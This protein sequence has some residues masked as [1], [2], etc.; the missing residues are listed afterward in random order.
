MSPVNHTAIYRV[1]SGLLIRRDQEQGGGAG[2]SREPRRGQDQG[3]GAGLRKLDNPLLQLFLNICSTD[4]V[5]VTLL[6]AALQTAVSE[7]HKLLRT[8]GVS[9][10]LT[11]LL[12][13]R[14]LTVSSALAGRNAR[15]SYSFFSPFPVPNKPPGFCGRYFFATYHPS[16]APVLPIIIVIDKTDFETACILSSRKM[17]KTPLPKSPYD[18][19]YSIHWDFDTSTFLKRPDVKGR[20]PKVITWMAPVGYLPSI[21]EP[22]RLRTCPEMP[23]R[24]TTSR[25][26]RAESAALIWN[27]PMMKESKPP[28]R[29]SPDQVIKLLKSGF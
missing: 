18:P 25:K 23:C 8:G 3:G 12:F 10:S 19:P 1:I 6:R 22:V 7:V 17:F 26:F 5:F 20:P 2:L 15:T 4:I 21:P 24:L 11:Y 9:T 29:T 16:N 13:W 27:A 28:E 14:W